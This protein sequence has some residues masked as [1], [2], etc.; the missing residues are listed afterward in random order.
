MVGAANGWKRSEAKKM[1][2]LMLWWRL[3]LCDV[4]VV[5]VLLVIFS[6][7][8]VGVVPVGSTLLGASSVGSRNLLLV[9]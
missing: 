6:V 7:S 9:L 3:L 4:V 1:G 5:V 8:V 2:V